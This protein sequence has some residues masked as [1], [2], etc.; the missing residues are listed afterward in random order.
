MTSNLLLKLV[1]QT[2]SGAYVG[3]ICS[4]YPYGRSILPFEKQPKIQG[5]EKI[6][7]GNHAW[8]RALHS[9][10]YIANFFAIRQ[11]YLIPLFKPNSTQQQL[12]R[13]ASNA[14]MAFGAATSI[15]DYIGYKLI[16]KKKSET[17]VPDFISLNKSLFYCLSAGVALTSLANLLTLGCSSI[18]TLE[19]QKISAFAFLVI[20][21]FKRL[22]KF[23]PIASAIL[24]TSRIVLSKNKAEKVAL[25]LW[26]ALDAYQLWN[27]KATPPN[28]AK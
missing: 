8:N 23:Q 14:L 27:T 7:E 16:E 13:Y 6:H 22:P 21:T 25:G 11:F 24:K 5:Q 1:S 3:F 4:P 2:S 15:L 18:K 19:I 9:L 26:L 12:V 20:F 28:T 17:R 10:A